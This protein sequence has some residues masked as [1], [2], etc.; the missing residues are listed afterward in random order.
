MSANKIDLSR[1]APARLEARVPRGADYRIRRHVRVLFAA[2]WPAVFMPLLGGT[3]S[4]AHAGEQAWVCP[5]LLMDAECAQYRQR[6]GQAGNELTRT[7][8]RREYEQVVAERRLACQ[9]H[10]TLDLSALLQAMHHADGLSR[11][12]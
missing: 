8:I 2:A 11:Q 7:R 12:R 6:L 4:P 1:P 5:S 10:K 9:C 3:A